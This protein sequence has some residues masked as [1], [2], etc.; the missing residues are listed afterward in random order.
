MKV[1]IAGSRSI[2]DFSIVEKAIEESEWKDEIT[3]VVSGTAKGVDK[4][5]ERWA[6]NNN[7]KIT[8]FPAEW[9]KYGRNAGPIRNKK[10]VSTQTV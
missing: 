10:W 7:I 9:K 3:E 4:L 6:M 1:I 5:G 8:Q 2:T